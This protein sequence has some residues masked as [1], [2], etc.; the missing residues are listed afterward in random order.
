MAC[1]TCKVELEFI[2][3]KKFHEG[4]RAAPFLLGEIGDYSSTAIASTF[5]FAHIADASSYSWL[6]SVKSSATINGLA[7]HALSRPARRLTL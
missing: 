4:S 3:T 5:T 6:A 1:T 2:G 7:H